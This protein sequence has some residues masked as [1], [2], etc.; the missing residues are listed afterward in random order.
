MGIFIGW[1]VFSL[2]I[3][4]IGSN[5]TIGFGASFFLSL[6]LSPVIGLIVVLVSKDQ[7]TELYKAQLMETQLKQENQL[8]ALV[9][10]KRKHSITEEVL[11][12]KKLLDEGII[13][14]EEFQ[15]AKAKVME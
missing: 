9:T 6:L 11:E 7:A 10:E 15:K 13:T 5:K 3:G 8:K 4:A 12:L 2:I 14:E 1:I